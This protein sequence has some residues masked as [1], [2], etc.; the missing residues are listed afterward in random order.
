MD[1]VRPRYGGGSLADVLPS[2]LAALGV[3]APDPLRLAGGALA[4][5]RRV[6]VLLVDGL[7]A[8]QVGLATPVAP[9]LAEI[10]AGRF[11]AA[12][13]LTAGFPSTTPTSLVSVGTG[14][15]PGAHGIMGFTVNVPGTDRVL[16]HTMWGEDPPPA[17]WQPV[18]TWFEKAAEA[19]VTVSVC[20][21]PEYEGSGLTVAAYRGAAYRPASEVDSLAAQ[22]LEAL[23][24]EP[25][26]LV[27]GYHPDLDHDGHLFGVASPEWQA[28]A[29]G[30]DRLLTRLVAGL[31]ADTALLV[32]ADHGQVDVPQERRVDVD[33]DPALRVGIR[34][35]AG[36][37]R[38]RYLHTVAGARDDVVAAWRSVLGDAAWVVTREEAVAAG[39]FGPVPE[40]H[41][42]RVGDVVVACHD[43][44]AVLAT[45]TEPPTVARLIAYH[46][47][48]T[49]D[50]MLIPLL[51]IRGDEVRGSVGGGR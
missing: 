40:A 36:E 22:M 4:G 19:G 45:R 16:V 27:Y 2:A 29:V 41:L 24:G 20:S 30:I 8:R 23:A 38:V 9:T 47:S 15:A 35:V 5:V 28:A 7:G 13:E 17:A 37:P 12:L 49:A 18:Q 14:A 43:R 44:T 42:L 39:W 26:V 1:L 48:Y 10:S 51:V 3:P 25:P 32:T 21:R 6:A 46:G 34:V 31:P 50:E 11:G 33:S